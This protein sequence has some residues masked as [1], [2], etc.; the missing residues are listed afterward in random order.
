[1]PVINGKVQRARYTSF[2]LNEL[3]S[4]DNPAQVGALAHIMKRRE[5]VAK[6][7][8]NLTAIAVAKYISSDDGAHSFEDVL[9]AN[10]FDEAIWPLTDALSQSIRSIM[11]DP[12]V[13]GTAQETA[14]TQTVTEFLAAVREISP[15]TEKRL[16]ELITK[17]RHVM[18]WEEI[19]K[20]AQAEVTSLKAQLTSTT[21]DAAT[22]K[23][24]L[25]AA[26]QKV[27]DLQAA[28]DKAMAEKDKAE[29]SLVEATDEVI[30]VGETEVR[31]SA[32]GEAQFSVTKALMDE[33]DMAR[34]EKRAETEFGHVTGTA[35]EK[36][37]VL[38]FVAA[39]PEETKKV[40][41]RIMASAETMAAKAFDRFG[42]GGGGQEPVADV[43]KAR[44]DY[45]GKVAEIEKRDGRGKAAAMKAARAE[46]AK[47]FAQAYPDQAA[48]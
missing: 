19:A 30:K 33:R 44:G 13:T 32:V 38:K 27:V 41:D 12:T 39:M 18:N 47:L 5:P 9:Q 4:V 36:A 28:K 11:G 34:I 45:N 37:A 17:G 14:V 2:K 7:T 26:E 40:F 25:T 16:A 10:N 1:M 6:S 48:N 3:S 43:A 35:V 8:P 20:A 42:H 24:A 15:D 29:K 22:A 23:A 46:H 31:K 21:A